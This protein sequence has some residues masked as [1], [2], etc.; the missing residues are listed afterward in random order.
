MA[1]F[2]LVRVRPE[3]EQGG[4]EVTD[5]G[6]FLDQARLGL[7]VVYDRLTAEV[8]A[9]LADAI[10]PS[11]SSSGFDRPPYLRD[12]YLDMRFHKA[13]HVQAGRFKRPFSRLELRSPGNLPF[14]GRGLT[15]NLIVEDGQWGDRALGLM[16]WG[17]APG[18]FTWYAAASNPDWAPD[19]DLEANGVDAIARLEWAKIDGLSIGVDF[20]HKFRA[21]PGDDTHV[22]GGGVDARLR[23]GPLF[24]LVD[25]IMAELPDMQAGATGSTPL[26][27]GVVGYGSY[28]IALRVPWRLQPVL[29]LEYADADSEFARTEALRAIAGINL[30]WSDYLRIMPQVEL[31]RPVGG[32]SSLHPWPAGETYYVMLSAQ[33]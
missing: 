23:Y 15:N 8:S 21:R 19:A 22:E 24:L 10:R 33:M 17:K 9:D 1:G 13:L 12:A 25:A 26:A 16:L 7:T 30:L 2:E 20:G 14:R 4:A 28:D 27:Y 11:S 3:P 29:L 5:Y 31:I 6:M 18:K 32:T